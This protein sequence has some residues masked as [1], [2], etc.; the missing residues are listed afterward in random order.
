MDYSQRFA[1]PAGWDGTHFDASVLL[2]ESAVRPRLR[3]VA[4]AYVYVLCRADGV[5]FYVGKGSRNARVLDHVREARNTNRL[6]HKLNVIR[7]MDRKCQLVRYILETD[8]EGEA[9]ALARE[10]ELIRHIGRHDLK[11]GPLTNQTD[12]GEGTSN[13]SEESRERRR[14]SLAGDGA[15][16]DGRALANQWFQKIVQVESVPVKNIGKYKVEGLWRNRESFGMSER[17]AG[18]IA[19]SAIAN[20]VLLEP[21]AII[22]RRMSVEGVDLIIE[23]GAGRD[24]LSS[25]MTVLQEPCSVGSEEL[26]LTNAGFNYVLTTIDTGLLLDAGVILPLEA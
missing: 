4:V 3:N 19:A 8:F 13:P 9:Q 23:N 6:T 26:V 20:R 12:G 24:T 5:P 22:P 15:D 14:A 10:R 2:K 7:S 25:D 1:V 17:Q 11:R 21:G 16:D 18:A